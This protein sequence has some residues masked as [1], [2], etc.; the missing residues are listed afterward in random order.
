MIGRLISLGITIAI[1]YF[2][3]NW[4]APDSL[5]LFTGNLAEA[6]HKTANGQAASK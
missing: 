1:I 2:V 5:H 4:L 3:W 6:V